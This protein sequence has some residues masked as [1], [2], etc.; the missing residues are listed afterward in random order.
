MLTAP[1]NLCKNRLIKS[2]YVYMHSLA[3]DSGP[4]SKQSVQQG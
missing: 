2:K 1:K 4:K 3:C